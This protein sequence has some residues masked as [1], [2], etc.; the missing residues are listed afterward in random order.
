MCEQRKDDEY[1]KD[2]K[3]HSWN[4]NCSGC[5]NVLIYEHIICKDMYGVN[6]VQVQQNVQEQQTINTV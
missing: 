5:H 3:G 4:F 6:D 2:T 1:E